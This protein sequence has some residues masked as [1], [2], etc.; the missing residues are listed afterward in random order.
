MHDHAEALDVAARLAMMSQEHLVQMGTLEDLREALPD[1][2]SS[3][4][5]IVWPEP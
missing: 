4:R 2:S 1:I 3:I 5:W